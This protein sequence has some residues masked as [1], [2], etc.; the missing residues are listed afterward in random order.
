MTLILLHNQVISSALELL[1]P[2]KANIIISSK[3]F[4]DDCNEVEAWFQT[5]YKSSGK[6]T[7]LNHIHLLSAL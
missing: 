4:K 2:D 6:S 1:T 5:P 7:T 3:M